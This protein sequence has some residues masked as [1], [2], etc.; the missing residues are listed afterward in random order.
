MELSE[1]LAE[2]APDTD[3]AT[4]IVRLLSERGQLSSAE[5]GRYLGMPKFTVSVA[6]S[7]LRQSGIVVDAAGTRPSATRAGRRGNALS[8]NAE[9]GTCVGMQHGPNHLHFI[10]AD[11]SHAVIEG[12]VSRFGNLRTVRIRRPDRPQRPETSLRNTFVR[13]PDVVARQIDVL[14][15][16][17]RYVR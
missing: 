3:N 1:W 12:V 14:P 6:V 4:R 9:L 16:R 13:V 2:G 5:I 8:L 17:R 11:V 7:E 15:A 10:V